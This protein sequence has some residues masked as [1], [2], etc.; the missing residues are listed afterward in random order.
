MVR[1]L[2]S[3]SC[4]AWLDDYILVILQYV[5]RRPHTSRS[6]QRSLFTRIPGRL[7]T[8][9]V[10]ALDGQAKGEPTAMELPQFRYELT[11]MSTH[12]SG[13]A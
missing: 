6:V 2:I 9:S 3:L 1:T 12:S 13:C 4:D 7:R 5:S 10:V 8:Q 11:L